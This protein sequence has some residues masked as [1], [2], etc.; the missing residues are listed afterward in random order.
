MQ[1]TGV[2]PL[3]Q[4]AVLPPCGTHST[5]WLSAVQGSTRLDQKAE[6]LLLSLFDGAPWEF[7]R[8]KQEDPQGYISQVGHR[9]GSWCS[10]A[11]TAVVQIWHGL[12]LHA[13]QSIYIYAVSAACA[14]RVTN[15]MC[16]AC[17]PACP[18]AVLQMRE[19]E[20]VKMKFGIDASDVQVFLKLEYSLLEVSRTLIGSQPQLSQRV[21]YNVGQHDAIWHACQSYVVLLAGA[22]VAV[23]LLEHSVPHPEHSSKAQQA[24][25]SFCWCL[26]RL[27]PN[28][29]G[30]Q[31]GRLR[32]DPSSMRAL[33]FDPVIDPILAE[34]QR[35]LSVPRRS[36]GGPGA[37]VL[38]M[39]GE[40][41]WGG[42]AWWGTVQHN[43]EL[44]GTAASDGNPAAP[45]G[46]YA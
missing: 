24:A 17:L 36:D 45:P 42:R 4:Q 22:C 46:S 39:A 37:D 19:W 33:V 9:Q 32:I 27:P 30:I 31:H 40:S 18:P 14:R 35:M 41:C 21:L 38:I 16:I 1:A 6:E 28:R 34:V 12:A 5:L 23:V 44:R 11:A 43:K 29:P 13:G 2:P 25:F 15:T 3:P 20:L 8:W 7:E 26:Q 10:A